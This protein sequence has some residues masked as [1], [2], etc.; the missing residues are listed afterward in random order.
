MLY[1]C[2]HIYLHVTLGYIEIRRYK[3]LDQMQ[4]DGSTHTYI[5]IGLYMGDRCVY[6]YMQAYT[7]TQRSPHIDI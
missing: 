4:V 3:C 1:I 5:H 2:I 7:K 6:V